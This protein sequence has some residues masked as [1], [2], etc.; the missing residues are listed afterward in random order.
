M[1]QLIIFTLVCLISLTAFAQNRGYELISPE[2]YEP[3]RAEILKESLLNFTLDVQFLTNMDTNKDA[4]FYAI[5]IQDEL[6]GQCGDFRHVQSI[7][8]EDMGDYKQRFNL[9]GHQ[10]IV[11]ALR[12]Q[13]CVV[14]FNTIKY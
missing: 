13:Q 1:R 2:G 14:V 3:L 10:N 4:K 12:E 8:H 6:P 9:R 7:P 11:E 5:Y